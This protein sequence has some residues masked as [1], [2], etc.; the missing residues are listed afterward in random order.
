[1]HPAEGSA[2]EDAEGETEADAKEERISI[3][4]A[5]EE[6]EGEHEKKFIP[7]PAVKQHGEYIF[8]QR[9]PVFPEVVVIPGEEADGPR[10]ADIEDEM[11]DI[12]F[13]C[14]YTVTLILA[15]EGKEEKEDKC[16]QFHVFSVDKGAVRSFPRGI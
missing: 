13:F 12:A 15:E 7:V 14:I 1:V 5:D 2:E 10:S 16:C 11:A 8:D 4:N 9:V 6:P 3:K